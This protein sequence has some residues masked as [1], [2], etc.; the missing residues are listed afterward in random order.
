MAIAT[1]TRT[2]QDIQSAVL[3]ELTWEPRVQPHEIGVTVAEGV[4]T[5]VFDLPLD[6]P[7]RRIAAEAEIDTEGDLILRRT[8]MADGRT[9]AFVNDQPVGVQVLRAIGAALVATWFSFNPLRKNVGIKMLWSVAAF[10]AMTILFGL[11][12]S[13]GLSLG[14]LALFGAADMMSVYVRSSLVQLHTPDRMRGRV[15]AVS[16]LAISASNELGEL[17]AGTAAAQEPPEAAGG[18]LENCVRARPCALAGP[19]GP[20]PPLAGQSARPA[21]C[22]LIMHHGQAGREV[23]GRAACPTP[24]AGPR[25]A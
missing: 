4:V 9:R 24:L 16:G 15:S 18:T 2:D 6:H 20:H 1:I 21:P 3:D 17:R 14:I 25:R 7:A 12:K 5:A 11:S 22:R 23:Q 10:G 8:Q 13:F 19:C